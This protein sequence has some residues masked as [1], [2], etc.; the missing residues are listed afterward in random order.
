MQKEGE[1]SLK[2]R[3]IMLSYKAHFMGS[4]YTNLNVH[5][6]FHTKSNNHCIMKE[7]DLPRIFRYIG[8][9]IK[10]MDGYPYMVGGRPDHIHI[11][12]TI[13]PKFGV[14]DFVRTIK[15]S[16]SKWIKS[17]ESCYKLFSWQEGYGAFSVSQSNVNAVVDY[18]SNQEQHH[19]ICT[20]H[21]EFNQFLL[22]HNIL[23]ARKS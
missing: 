4:S 1:L 10:T 8:G 22:K 13:P 18:I 12:T 23:T 2:K 14:S 6:I 20:T 21:E 16:S 3:H 17:I 7:D 5:I 11:L 15:A 9:I 19:R